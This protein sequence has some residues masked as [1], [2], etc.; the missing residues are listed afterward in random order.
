MKLRCDE[1]RVRYKQE[2]EPEIFDSAG[3]HNIIH[4]GDHDDN[5][6]QIIGW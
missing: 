2:I 4:Q 3:K 6:S 5:N 1:K